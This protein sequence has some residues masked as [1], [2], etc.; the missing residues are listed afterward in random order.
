MLLLLLGSACPGGDKGTTEADSGPAK[1][2][3]GSDS[4]VDTAPVEVDADGDGH[5]AGE[6]CDD[7][8]AAVFENEPDPMALGISPDCGEMV[9]SAR[10]Y[11][12]QAN[13]YFDGGG[14]AGDLNGDGY[15]DLVLGAALVVDEDGVRI[16]AQYVV[17]GPVTGDE[18]LAGATARIVGDAEDQTLAGAAFGLGDTDGDGYD[19]LVIQRASTAEDVR[20]DSLILLG[21]VSGAM[22]MEVYDGVWTYTPYDMAY[23]GTPAGD[24]DGD[25]LADMMIRFDYG[26]PD[27]GIGIVLGP[28]T[29]EHTYAEAVATVS[30][31]GGTGVGDVDGD[32][33]ED[34]GAWI[35]GNASL[36]LGPLL[37]DYGYTDSDAFFDVVDYV[38]EAAAGDTNGDGYGDIMLSTP[39][40]WEE[41]SDC[42]EGAVFIYQGPV[43]GGYVPYEDADAT[44]IGAGCGDNAWA[45]ATAEDLN[46]DG[47]SDIIVGAQRYRSPPGRVYVNLGPVSGRRSEADAWWQIEGAGEI[48]TPVSLAD[49]AGDTNG[50]GYG[51][52][53][54]AERG[55]SI[56]NELD[57]AYY[58]LLGG[59]T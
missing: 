3:S 29:G 4:T 54:L 13:D 8:D 42:Y 56:V 58:I 53:V 33:M 32:G 46:G 20:S 5:P 57:G 40:A 9:V 15:D 43:A 31:S 23:T 26:T 49:S 27:Q 17:S 14:G 6:D 36:F 12:E 22:N 35:Y 30:C 52:A 44:L 18:S 41:S 37:G 25:G 7:E 50:D 47:L 2:D 19:D 28:L 1:E 39:H 48:S 55:A 34:T 21:P 51:D 59:P 38:F 24:A 45:P 11:G 10:R 16:A